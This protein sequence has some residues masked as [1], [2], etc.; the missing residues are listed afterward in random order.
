MC[1][2]VQRA[3]VCSRG[4]ECWLS[5][6]LVQGTCGWCMASAAVKKGKWL[7]IHCWMQDRADKWLSVCDGPFCGHFMTEELR[8]KLNPPICLAP[9]RA[10]TPQP[11]PEPPL[12][13]STPQPPPE[14][15][16][17]QP[18]QPQR[19][20]QLR[21]T[22]WSPVFPEPLPPTPSQFRVLLLALQQQRQEL[23]EQKQELAEQKQEIN[24]LAWENAEL[25]TQV[26][27]LQLQLCHS[28]P[29]PAA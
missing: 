3:L 17:P 23:A 19:L 9:L 10:S 29:K 21:L 28:T 13:A 4:G 15:F 7:C 8:R 26:S 16:A 1:E 2:A 14:P 18:Q 22:D 11:P 24:D 12:R 6:C 20:S 27:V 25:A 5:V